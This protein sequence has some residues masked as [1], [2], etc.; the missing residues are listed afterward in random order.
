MTETSWGH[1][2]RHYAVPLLAAHEFTDGTIYGRPRK[3]SVPAATRERWAELLEKARP[4]VREMVERT[5][6]QWNNILREYVR[7]ETGLRLTVGDDAQAVPVKID[8]G[9][10]LPF[11][12]ILRRFEGLEWLV[13]N[14]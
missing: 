11:V 3:A 6:R 1:P 2:I 10:P 5:Y 4:G 13:L 14:R 8:G 9:M 7:A 12:E